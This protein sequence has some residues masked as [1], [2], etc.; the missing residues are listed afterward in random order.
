[1][2]I[3]VPENLAYLPYQEEGVR[4]MVKRSS[5]LLGDEMGLGKSVQICGLMNACPDIVRTLIICPASLKTNWLRELERW[6]PLGE[7]GIASGKHW[8]DTLTVIINYD[9]LARHRDKIRS[10]TWDLL[11][12]DECHFCKNISSQRTKEVVG[13]NALAP[14][15]A[16]RK[17]CL[18][19]TPIVNRPI[20]LYP[21]LRFLDPHAW[22]SYNDF[23]MR[24]CGGAGKVIIQRFGRPENSVAWRTFCAFKGLQ[25]KPTA[26]LAVWD[27]FVQKHRP[28]GVQCKR[29]TD[30]HGA[31]NL[32]EL[33][34]KL[35]G[36]I[37]LRRTKAEVLTDLP[38]KFRQVVE[39]DADA[40]TRKLLQQEKT[41][42]DSVL[43]SNAA[44]QL[45]DRDYRAT[46]LQMQDTNSAAWEEISI[47]RHELALIKLPLAI[48]HLEECIESVGKVVCFCHHQEFAAGLAQHFGPQAVSLVG[49]TPLA[50]RQVAVDLFQT[51]PNIQLFIGSKA[52][53]EG[54][55]LT[56]SSHVVLAEQ[57]WVPGIVSQMEDRCHR[58]GQTDSVT[59]Q[60]LVLAD[61]LDV[62]I[63]K[64][65]V[66]K[67]LIIGRV[68][69]KGEA[70]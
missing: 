47:I 27:E 48:V 21:I 37:M 35:Y 30:Y 70:Q 67:Q 29:L 61:S 9:I 53:A 66:R 56:A 69:E 13:S 58:I 44:E 10:Q 24:Y 3:P 7:Y 34:G 50:A 60:H 59:C 26:D 39:L 63:A 22:P 46:V 68:M 2:N 62:Q 43:G 36:G 52:A 6:C 32:D 65:I 40:G 15:P 38:P 33:R 45:T 17:V 11:V 31:S 8:P 1:M 25:P 14:I 57:F 41:L 49:S 16:L 54:I 42:W 12:V 18:T 19:G 20:E 64:T 55:T 51:D 23:G 4:Y 28:Y 5:V